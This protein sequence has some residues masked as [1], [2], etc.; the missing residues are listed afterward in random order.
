V[1]NRE[2]KHH[3]VAVELKTDEAEVHC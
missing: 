1:E 3:K 2:K